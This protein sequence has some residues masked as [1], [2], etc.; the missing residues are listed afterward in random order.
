MDECDFYLKV[1]YVFKIVQLV[2]NC[3]THLYV[4]QKD[5]ARLILN[6]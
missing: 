6:Y 1:F 4:L 2:P 5:L 3:A